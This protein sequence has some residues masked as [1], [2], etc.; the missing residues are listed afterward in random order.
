MY[1]KYNLT[2][3]SLNMNEIYHHI[4]KYIMRELALNQSL[5]FAQMRPPKVESNLYAYYLKKLTKSGYITKKETSYSLSSIGLAYV[6]KLSFVGDSLQLR[7]QPKINTGI[8]LKNI[9]NEILLTRR[10]RQPLFGLWGLPMGKIHEEDE[11]IH[12]AAKRE[13]FEKCGIKNSNLQHVGGCYMK[14]YKDDIVVSSSISQ[15][16]LQNNF[17]GQ[18]SLGKDLKWVSVEKLEK[19]RLIPGVIEVIRAAELGK[20]NFF[21]ETNKMLE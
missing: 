19:V 15:I 21:V 5:R 11:T 7:I 12:D 4:E 16:F 14:F 8:I 2:Q 10:R 13:L 1:R 18:V 20:G 9:H 3:N 17:D 6:D